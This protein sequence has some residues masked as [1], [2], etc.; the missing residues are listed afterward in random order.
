MTFRM[1]VLGLSFLF[2]SAGCASLCNRNEKVAR[3]L[4]TQSEVLKKIIV[5]REK[6]DFKNR[7]QVDQ[8]LMEQEMVLMAGI[9]SVVKSEDMIVDLQCKSKQCRGTNASE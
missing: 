1:F 3:V 2:L 9:N 7:L 5:L 4:R 6:E 8:V